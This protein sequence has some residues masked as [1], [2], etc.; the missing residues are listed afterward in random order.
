[1]NKINWFKVLGVSVLIHIILIA[2]TFLAVFIYSIA[3]NTGQSNEFYEAFAQ[4]I[5]PYISAICGSILIYYF[6]LRLNKGKTINPFIIGLG[7]PII[8][9]VIDMLIII[10]MVPDW[11]EGVSTIAISNGAKLLAGILASFKTKTINK[12]N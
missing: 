9:I 3:I 11:T 10:L 4:K 7:L 2:L 8:Y 5:G 1:M 12:I 6:V